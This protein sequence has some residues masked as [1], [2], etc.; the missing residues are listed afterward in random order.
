ME[1]CGRWA[2][3]SCLPWR[4]DAASPPGCTPSGCLFCCGPS[5]SWS[6]LSSRGHSGSRGQQQR[7]RHWGK[8]AFNINN[9]LLWLMQTW[10]TVCTFCSKCVELISSLLVIHIIY[11]LYVYRESTYLF[12][13]QQIKFKIRFILFVYT[14]ALCRSLSNITILQKNFTYVFPKQP[15]SWCLFNLLWPLYHNLPTD[16]IFHDRKLLSGL[17]P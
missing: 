7:K 3:R 8:M 15:F 6:Q 14:F 12:F 1:V 2:A 11:I 5:L 4:P 13:I 10:E 16:L 17:I 9:V